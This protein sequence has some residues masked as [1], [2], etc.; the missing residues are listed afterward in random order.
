[1]PFVL[2][3]DA[4]LTAVG[5]TLSQSDDCKHDYAVAYASKHLT[6][7]QQRWDTQS[8]EAF[9]VVWAM[10]P[11]HPHLLGCL[12]TLVTD[13]SALTLLKSANTNPKIARWGM[14]L[15]EFDFTVKHHIGKSNANAD[16]LSCLTTASD[17][18]A[19]DID[20]PTYKP[21]TFVLAI[22]QD[23]PLPM[24]AFSPTSFK[25][26]AYWEAMVLA[27]KANPELAALCHLLSA[28]LLAKHCP[29]NTY[30]YYN[31]TV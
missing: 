22:M 30:I 10:E 1:M 19:V 18:M 27:Q 13:H 29:S 21:N 2:Q 11:F 20:V 6:A 28:H 8:C 15:A 14:C 7:Q 16:A 17:P 25:E 23:Q 3:T 12:F 26:A 31:T 5:A 4:S 24:T 9:T